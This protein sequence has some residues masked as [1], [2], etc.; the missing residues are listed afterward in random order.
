MNKPELMAQIR[1]IWEYARGL[2]I[3]GVFSGPAPLEASDNFKRA[4]G[5]P[6]ASYEELYLLGLRESQYNIL[7]RDYS[8]FQFGMSGESDVRFAYYPNPF[9]GASSEA[10][11]E[12]TEMQEYVSEG[13]IDVDEFLHRASE[14]RKSQHP[15]LVRY[16]FALG[17]YV[18][19]THPCSHLHLGF[20]PDSRW[21]VRRFLTAKAFALLIFRLFYLEFWTRAG[22]LRE[23]ATEVTF[24]QALDSAKLESRLL[25]DNEFSEAETR[26]F[27]LT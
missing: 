11:A 10:V 25:Y 7:L 5:D 23:G 12:L 13:I 15:P 20:H 22:P 4:A 14:I 9:F 27:H 6:S 1:K 19:A 8:F 17:Q 24:D 2:Q 16:D 26:R 21:P 18:E 3:D